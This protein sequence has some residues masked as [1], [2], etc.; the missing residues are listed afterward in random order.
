M[1]VV[2]IVGPQAVGKMTVGQELERQ[3]QL[4]LFHNHETI[5]LVSKF[6]SYDTIEGKSLVWNFRLDIFRA[7]AGSDLSGLITTFSWDFDDPDDWAFIAETKRI[8]SSS[9]V[10]FAVVELQTSLDERRRRNKSANRLAHKPSKRDAASSEAD[11]LRT[12][13]LR[14]QNSNEADQIPG[15]HLKFDNT[16]LLP[17]DV[18]I[19]IRKELGF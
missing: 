4:V 11:L 2:I 1:H 3:T 6:F 15:K 8:F 12:A 9:H 5:D 19:S 16:H 14:R 10:N 18:V 13:K 7:V 17:Q